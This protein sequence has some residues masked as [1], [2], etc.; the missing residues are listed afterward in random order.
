MVGDLGERV[1]P[2]LKSWYLAVRNYPGFDNE[3]MQS[4]AELEAIDRV[5]KRYQG[6]EGTEIQVIR[7]SRRSYAVAMIDTDTGKALPQL[8]LFTGEFAL[9][10]ATTY[11]EDLHRKASTQEPEPEPVDEALATEGQAILKTMIVE[12]QAIEDE[13]GNEV[14]LKQPADAAL[15][16]LDK[17]MNTLK[18]LHECLRS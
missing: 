5:V 7:S 4:E 12:V 15:A 1:R 2:Y 9:R 6:E 17:Q 13:T 10:N 14:T 11:A 8:R 16:E 18:A 3:G